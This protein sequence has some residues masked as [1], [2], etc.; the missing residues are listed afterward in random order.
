MPSMRN[1][2]ACLL[3]A[4]LSQGLAGCAGASYGAP[5]TTSGT[6]YVSASLMDA[7]FQTTGGTVTA[8]NIAVSKVELVGTGGVQTVATFSPSQEINLLN[9]ETAPLQLGTGQVSA[10]TYQQLRLVLD[11]SQADNTSVVINGV[12]YPLSIPSAT[13]IGF[14]G[15]TSTDNGDG[16]GTSG[17]KVNIGLTAQAG[18]TYGFIIDFNAAES[19]VQTGGGSYLMKPVLVATAQTASGTIAGTVKNNAG[20]PVSGAEIVA[21]QAGIAINSGVSDMSG[22]YAINALPAGS[23]TLVVNNVWTSQA[24]AAETASGY[25]PSA[26]SSFTVPGGSLTV[27]SGQSTTENITD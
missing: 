21:M 25:D 22:N 24:G 4:G 6:A 7:P 16:V 23:Y 15:N 12:T 1:F 14:G 10:G 20:N 9:Y 27:T 13:G 17:V 2:I 18:Q 26:G 5:G 19:I 11:T 3:A 8:V